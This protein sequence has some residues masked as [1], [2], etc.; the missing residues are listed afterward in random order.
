MLELW[1]GIEPLLSNITFYIACLI[2]VFLWYGIAVAA[3]HIYF[4]N[5][6]EAIESAARGAWTSVAAT[7]VLA[8]LAGYFVF[9]STFNAPANS[10]ALA[11][12]FCVLIV[13]L[14]FTFVLTRGS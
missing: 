10:V 9:P 8:A 11:I 1:Q 3:T 14:L 2:A 6:G 13:T 5:G 4:G 12:G 7:T